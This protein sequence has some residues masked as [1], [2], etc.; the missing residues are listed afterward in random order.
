MAFPSQ[1]TIYPRLAT[2]IPDG[3]S[4]NPRMRVVTSMEV[5]C[6]DDQRIKICIATDGIVLLFLK[7]ALR[8]MVIP[9]GI[10]S[11]NDFQT[12]RILVVAAITDTALL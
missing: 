11:L 2:F 10:S 4:I 7:L 6:S 5:P 12:C 3:S 9:L 1:Y 8:R